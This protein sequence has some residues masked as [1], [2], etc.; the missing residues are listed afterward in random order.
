MTMFMFYFSKSLRGFDIPALE[1][2]YFKKPIITS[3]IPVHR[4]V[5]KDYPW[6]ISPSHDFNFESAFNKAIEKMDSNALV[7]KKY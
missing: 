4:E 1:A 3:D 2:V 6:Y 7:R 5:L